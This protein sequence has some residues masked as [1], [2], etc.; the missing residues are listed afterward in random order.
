MNNN[1]Q[2]WFTWLNNQNPL[3]LKVISRVWTKGL[4]HLFSRENEWL[5]VF[6]T[7]NIKD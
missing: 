7:K 1:T 5:C 3:G 4:Q 2:A 6:V